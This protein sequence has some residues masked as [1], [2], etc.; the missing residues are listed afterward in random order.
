MTIIVIESVAYLDIGYS[1]CCAFL[2][3]KGKD[4]PLQSAFLIQLSFLFLLFPVYN[5]GEFIVQRI[6]ALPLS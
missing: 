3:R 2:Y 4:H 5:R 1:L 6:L